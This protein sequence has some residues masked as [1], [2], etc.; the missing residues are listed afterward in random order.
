VLGRDGRACQDCGA[1]STFE[2]PLHVHHLLPFAEILAEHRPISVE[3]AESYSALWDVDNGVTLCSECHR[4]A[5]A[6]DSRPI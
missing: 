3:Q 1:H 4:T 2:N 6:T 5:H